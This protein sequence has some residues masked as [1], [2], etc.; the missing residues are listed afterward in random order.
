MNETTTSCTP[1]AAHWETG[2]LS[3]DHALETGHVALLGR[4]LKVSVDNGDGQED[5]G[6][7]A[8]SSEK[9]AADGESTDASTAESG[10]GGDHPLEFLVH[11]LL[12]VTGHDKTLL[13][14]LLGNV[15]WGRTR[16]LD[17]GLG[18]DGAGDEHV[19]GEDGGLERVGKSLGDAE[20][21]GPGIQSM[22][23][24]QKKNPPVCTHM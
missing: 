23:S 7:T 15:T 19:D 13:L 12:A 5:T 22:S 1:T 9:I 21:R 8:Q 20:R 24:F 18:E 14:E 3:H 10:S 11:G 2:R 6:S 16:D 17:P 4:D